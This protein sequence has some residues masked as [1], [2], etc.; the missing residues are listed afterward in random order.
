MA[1][2]DDERTQESDKDNYISMLHSLKIEK[3]VE[4][5]IKQLRTPS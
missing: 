5:S 1:E 2:T 3:L 4:S